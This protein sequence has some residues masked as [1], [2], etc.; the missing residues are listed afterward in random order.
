MSENKTRPTDRSVDQVLDAINDPVKHAD[1]RHL[2]DLIERLSGHPAVMWGPSIIG[3][4]SWH[5]RY[6]SGREGDSPA[7][8]FAP[9]ASSITL[10]ITGGFEEMESD[11]ARLGKHKTGKGC[12]YIKRLA[13]IDLDVLESVIQSSLEAA[14]RFDT[15]HV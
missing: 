11:L 14:S 9:R 1:C 7:V 2:R 8:G 3:F 6:D 10:Y 15:R 5:Y 4:G 13:D 12:L